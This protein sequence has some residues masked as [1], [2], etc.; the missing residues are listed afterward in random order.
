MT[1]LNHP[2]QAAW[3]D[4]DKETAELFTLPSFDD[5]VTPEE[6]LAAEA[7]LYAGVIRELDEFEQIRA[8]NSGPVVA[9]TDL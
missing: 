9:V 3:P 5:F 1:N 2:A 7:E 6:V 4:A 8:A